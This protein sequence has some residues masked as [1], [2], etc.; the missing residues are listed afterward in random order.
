MY[1]ND[2]LG[3]DALLLGLELRVKYFRADFGMTEFRNFDLIILWLFDLQFSSE[4]RI[5]ANPN[6]NSSLS[7]ARSESQAINPSA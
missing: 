4:K 6:S 3:S 7:F 2:L 5:G 1:D